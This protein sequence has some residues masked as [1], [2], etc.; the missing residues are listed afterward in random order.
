MSYLIANTDANGVLTLDFGFYYENNLVPFQ[1][2][3]SAGV[4][5]IMTS[6][7]IYEHFDPD[8]PATLSKSILTGLLRNQLRYKGVIIT[9]D[10]E[11]GAIENEGELSEAAVESFNAGADLL[12]ICQSHEKA[13][14]AFGALF[15]AIKKSPELHER[16]QESISRVTGLREL[17]AQSA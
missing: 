11:M 5:S 2:A 15:S 17:Y 8:K 6:H 7:T 9:D 1:K 3:I 10:L 13:I 14:D 4:A 16:L 12:L